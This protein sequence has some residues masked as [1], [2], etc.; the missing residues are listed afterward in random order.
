[1]MP[2]SASPG[3]LRL[4][5]MYACR[6]GLSHEDAQDC[7]SDFRLHLLR[8]SPACLDSAAW[9]HRCAHNFASNYRRSQQRR[10]L[11]ERRYSEQAGVNT[12]AAAEPRYAGAGPKTLT[13]R[14][15]LWEQ[16][17]TTLRQ[18]TPEQ[19]DLFLRYHLRQQNLAQ[20]AERT[21]RTPAA[22]TQAIYHIH[23]RL[24]RLLLAQGWTVT[25][26]R[27]FVCSTPPPAVPHSRISQQKP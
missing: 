1:M 3:P 19:R 26:A 23:R 27:Q 5:Y 16:V 24:A 22:V 25:E 17:L 12:A 10:Q 20:L 2:L 6:L 8:N 15:A 7:A 13:L 9:L 11:R 18:F 14:N 4:A 21:G